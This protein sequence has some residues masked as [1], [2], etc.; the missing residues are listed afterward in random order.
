[1]NAD[2]RAFPQTLAVDANFTQ[3]LDARTG[4]AAV[5]NPIL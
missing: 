2:R 4:M 3:L 5:S 1:V